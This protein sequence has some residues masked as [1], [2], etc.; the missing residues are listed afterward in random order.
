MLGNRNQRHG[1]IKEELEDAAADHDIE[2]RMRLKELDAD[3]ASID[4]KLLAAER[5]GDV[6]EMRRLLKEQSVAEKRRKNIQNDQAMMKN[7]INDIK[8]L[9]S[10]AQMTKMMRMSGKMYQIAAR[11]VKP[12]EIASRNTQ[13]Q[14]NRAR[15]AE[16]MASVRSANADMLEDFMED[17]LEDDDDDDDERLRAYLERRETEAL[18][19]ESVGASG[20]TLPSSES[21]ARDRIMASLTRAAQESRQPVAEAGSD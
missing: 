9:E 6:S 3:F 7:T 8:D 10:S 18:L 21:T 5:R 4:K 14:M 12:A 19:D 20:G 17:N 13:M 11:T 15:V 1:N 16:A 2:C